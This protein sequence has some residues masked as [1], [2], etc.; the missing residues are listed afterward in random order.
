M[1]GK[2]EKHELCKSCRKIHSVMKDGSLGDTIED[3]LDMDVYSNPSAYL[4]MNVG[5][6]GDLSR[7]GGCSKCL[8]LVE[9]RLIESGVTQ[10][11]INEWKNSD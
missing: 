9:S 2:I 6:H 5:I 7:N 4:M 10:E 8:K 3:L 1:Q 11:Q